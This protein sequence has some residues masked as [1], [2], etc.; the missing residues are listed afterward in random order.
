M[1]QRPQP[2]NFIGNYA[3]GVGPITPLSGTSITLANNQKG[4]YIRTTSGSAVTLTVPKNSD[5]SIPVEAVFNVEQAGAGQ[6]TFTAASG[7][8]IHSAGGKVAT[9]A[10]YAVATI[11][12]VDTDTW[13]LCGNL[14]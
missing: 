9:A 8:T 13:T 10:Q 4:K 3:Q 7:V 6:V 5:V 12:K 2:V 1:P 11:I 14:A